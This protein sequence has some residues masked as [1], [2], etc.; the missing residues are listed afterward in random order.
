M[1]YYN[2]F[3]VYFYY[4]KIYF[5]NKK[6]RV[7]F[8]KNDNY[9]ESIKKITF[10]DNQGIA[11][12]FL[13]NNKQVKNDIL[14]SKKFNLSIFLNSHYLFKDKHIQFRYEI[15]EEIKEERI[16]KI[17][18]KETRSNE[19]FFLTEFNDNGKNNLDQLYL[20]KKTVSD[21]IEPMVSKNLIERIL[22]KADK[23]NSSK[24]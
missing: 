18:K 5:T 16:L 17:L 21:L 12:E 14:K 4:N 7:Y 24:I 20:D 22:I 23:K 15:N 6:T 11:R 1:N 8:I 3:L 13:Y 10:N 19:I 9:Q 2:G